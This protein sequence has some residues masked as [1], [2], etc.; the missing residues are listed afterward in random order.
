MWQRR[1]KNYSVYILG[2]SQMR[3]E[4]EKKNPASTN[5]SWKMCGMFKGSWT[6]RCRSGYVCKYMRVCC[7]SLDRVYSSQNG[8]YTHI[9]INT[10]LSLSFFARLSSPLLPSS[11]L[12]VWNR[13]ILWEAHWNVSFQKNFGKYS[14]LCYLTL[15]SVLLTHTHIVSERASVH[16]CAHVL[17]ICS[18]QYTTAKKPYTTRSP[19]NGKC[20]LLAHK[21]SPPY[22]ALWV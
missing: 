14:Y 12:R 8:I 18:L 5:K 2:A 17:Y 15:P 22:M 1:K 3:N 16:V 10:S 9:Y 19:P 21:K 11:I 20:Y 7:N 6:V 4:K 13:R